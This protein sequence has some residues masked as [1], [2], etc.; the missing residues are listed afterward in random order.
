MSTLYIIIGKKNLIVKIQ[1]WC[2]STKIIKKKTF[3]IL[4]NRFADK[5][6]NLFICFHG[7]IYMHE[8]YRL[9]MCLEDLVNTRY[10]VKG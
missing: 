4:L 8:G 3:Y 6:D 5:Y 1:I 7:Q 2:F 10:L 9:F